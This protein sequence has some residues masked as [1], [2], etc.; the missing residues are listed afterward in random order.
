MSAGIGHPMHGGQ[1][2]RYYGGEDLHHQF[3]GGFLPQN[4]YFANDLYIS[5]PKP[6]MPGRR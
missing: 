6:P 3:S 1:H 2:Q 5:G 4:Q